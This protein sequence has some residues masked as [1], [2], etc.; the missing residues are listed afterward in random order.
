MIELL[1]FQTYVPVSGHGVRLEAESPKAMEKERP[2]HSCLVVLRLV[3]QSCPA[4][5]DPMNYS[6]SGS[7]VPEDSSGKNT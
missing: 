6:P 3:I 2:G 1:Y 7:P 5:C 4:V